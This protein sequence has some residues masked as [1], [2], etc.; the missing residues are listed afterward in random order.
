MIEI[1]VTIVIVSFGLL[2]LAGFTT[3]ASALAVEANQRARAAA[4]LAD[5]GNR[6]ANNKTGAAGY[7]SANALGATAQTGCAAKA[8][9][10][11]RD[12]C[13]WNNQLFGASDALTSGAADALKFRGCITRPVASDPVY[14]VTVAWAATVPGVPPADTCALDAFGDDAFRRTLRTQV[15]VA[16]LAA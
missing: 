15:R 4:I 8:S 2:G 16:A 6:I 5:M 13:E 3:R 10:A 9:L 7:V 11:L 1:L 14:V 12:L